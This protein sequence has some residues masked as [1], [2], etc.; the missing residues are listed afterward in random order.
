MP[1]FLLRNGKVQF[2][3]TA[4]DSKGLRICGQQIRQDGKEMV[5]CSALI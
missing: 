3:V 5:T 2:I 4:Q 1:D